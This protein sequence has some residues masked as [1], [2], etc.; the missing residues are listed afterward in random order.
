MHTFQE[1][2]STHTSNTRMW[3]IHLYGVQ[4][5]LPSIY[6]LLTALGGHLVL[7]ITINMEKVIK[8]TFKPMVIVS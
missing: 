3:Y 7:V 8:C 6:V 2:D 4:Y 1:R 5:S